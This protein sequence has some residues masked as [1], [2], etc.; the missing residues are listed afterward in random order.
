MDTMWDTMDE[1]FDTRNPDNLI[2]TWLLA[3]LVTAAVAGT[4]IV[5]G[6]AV[7]GLF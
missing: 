1:L 7:G 5:L 6:L 3:I 2:G 4:L